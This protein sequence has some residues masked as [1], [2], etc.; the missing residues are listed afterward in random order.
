MAQALNFAAKT[1]KNEYLI[2]THQDISLISTDW[3]NYAESFLKSILNCGIAGLVGVRKNKTT[4]KT[5]FLNRIYTGTPPHPWGSTI[6]EPEQV[7]SLDE[8]I[9]IIPKNVFQRLK[10]DEKTCDRWDLYMVDYCLAVKRM[11][12]QPYVLPL[13]IYHVG[14]RTYI[15]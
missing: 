6:S 3:L 4:G 9:A 10:F 5:D 14:N 12:L 8:C 1:A 13:E 15:F 7:N 2:F 11:N